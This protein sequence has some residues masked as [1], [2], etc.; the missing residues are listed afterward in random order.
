MLQK[1]QVSTRK[2]LVH[3]R[4]CAQSKKILITSHPELAATQHW[5]SSALTLDHLC[6][7]AGGLILL[8]PTGSRN[9]SNL[10]KKTNVCL[11]YLFISQL[12]RCLVLFSTLSVHLA[13]QD[14]LTSPLIEA[15]EH[16][17]ILCLIVFWLPNQIL[18]IHSAF[19]LTMAI[20]PTTQSSWNQH[21][22]MTAA[23]GQAET[24]KE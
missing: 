4:I 22:R 5:W 10:K 18:T 7:T 20:F 16:I 3:V 17:Q 1:P 21:S 11:P 13:E 23:P 9:L 24:G 12:S 14:Y 15:Q 2:S 8:K 6:H 19:C